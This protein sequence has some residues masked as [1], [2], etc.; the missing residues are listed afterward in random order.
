MSFVTIKQLENKGFNSLQLCENYINTFLNVM[1]K[2]ELK[3]IKMIT[4]CVNRISLKTYWFM[5][6]SDNTINGGRPKH[7]MDTMKW[8]KNEGLDWLV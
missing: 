3:E 8:L 6:Y 5:T 4:V 1:T 2:E 7:Y